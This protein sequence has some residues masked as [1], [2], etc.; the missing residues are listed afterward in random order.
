M[1]KLIEKGA[2]FYPDTF[3]PSGYTIMSTKR[4]GL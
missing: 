3:R 2:I 1:E 4:V